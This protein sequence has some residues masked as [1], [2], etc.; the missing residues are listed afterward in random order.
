MKENV[1][2]PVGTP[3]PLRLA[4]S[5]AYSWSDDAENWT[6]KPP[7]VP[8]LAMSCGGILASARMQGASHAR[9]PERQVEHRPRMARVDDRMELDA[10]G[11]RP[12]DNLVDHVVADLPGVP[13]VERDERLAASVSLRARHVTLLR[14]VPT[15]VEDERVSRPQIAREPP[16]TLR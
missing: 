11:Q 16:Q 12:H 1:A 14:A 7:L 2:A 15:V 4:V 6:A 9:G 5:A 8:L 10:L 13:R 3:V